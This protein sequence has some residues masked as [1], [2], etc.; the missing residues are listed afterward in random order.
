MRH[1]LIIFEGLPCSGK[2]TL[3]AYIADRL[4]QKEKI[5]FVDEG[6]GDHP[7][8]YEFHALA[9]AGLLSSESRIVPL[10]DFSGDLLHQLLPYKIYDGLP[11]EAEKP[12]MLEN[13]GNSFGRQIRMQSMCSTV[14][15]CRIRCARR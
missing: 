10:S 6:T 2:S 4:G 7:T 8:D 15:F 1:H 14:C 5:R 3:S 11:W 13:G 9:P 12:L